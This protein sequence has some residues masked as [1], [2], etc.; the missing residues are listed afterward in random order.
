MKEI[1]KDVVG[2]EGRYKVSDKGRVKSIKRKYRKND[3]ILTQMNHSDGYKYVNLYKNGVAESVRSVHVLVIE[4]FKRPLKEGEQTNHLDRDKTN[5][6][7]DNLEIVNARE[8][9]SHRN[10]TAKGYYFNKTA[11]KWHAQIRINGEHEYLGLY[12]TEEE[13]HKAYLNALE[14][15]GLRNKYANI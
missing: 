10:G 12:E 4:A 6:C 3:L 2:Y 15:N 14:E 5:N 11:Q 1:W 13:A 8:N 9:L 7:I